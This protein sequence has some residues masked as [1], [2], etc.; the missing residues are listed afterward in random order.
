MF[1]GGPR[2]TMKYMTKLHPTE[3]TSRHEHDYL[4]A[5]GRDAF[6]PFYDLFTAVLGAGGVHRALVDQARLAAGQRVLEIGCGTGSL[7]VRAKRAC[8]GIELTGSDPDPLALD[9]ARRKARRL[10]GIRFERGYAQRL[11]YPDAAFDR[12]LSSLMFHHLDDDA[13]AATAAE[14]FRVLRPGGSLHLVDF[15][16]EAHGA[17]AY[18]KRRM[19]KSG[20]HLA[21]GGGEA[22]RR[23]LASAS[24][25]C[26][27][28]VTRRHPILG[29]I[30]YYRATRPA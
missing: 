21:Q 17:H 2:I 22:I 27:E 11:P 10:T 26:P 19:A 16:G 20:G 30:A 4:P 9:R 24:L 1:R 8:P 23:L 28:P 13:K 29:E 6:L 12:V 25:D 14:V 15:T 3:H 5:A 7:S 18:V